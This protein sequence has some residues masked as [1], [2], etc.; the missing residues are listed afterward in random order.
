MNESPL[1]TLK[2]RFQ[3]ML[4]KGVLGELGLIQDGDE[5][6]L[7]PAEMQGRER[8]IVQVH[9]ASGAARRMA[10]PL[11]A[12]LGRPV[13]AIPRHRRGMPQ[14]PAG[15][16]GSLAHDATLAVAIAAHSSPSC[17]GIGVDIEPSVP[18][19]EALV[20]M[21]A[22]SWE[23]KAIHAGQIT[24]KQLFCIKEAVFKAV[25]P[26]DEVF[27]EFRDVEV[28]PA[29]GTALTR[30]GRRVMWRLINDPHHVAVAWWWSLP[31][32]PESQIRLPSDGEPLSLQ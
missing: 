22:T 27:L 14:W 19:D 1:V 30:Y 15:I 9:R 4:P 31:L 12:N 8:A 20:S 10:K 6:L 11:C 24:G 32:V 13:E 2:Q 23:Q 18:L 16:V 17:R 29:N 26:H 25:Y 28:D 5:W 7:S 3:A 21:V